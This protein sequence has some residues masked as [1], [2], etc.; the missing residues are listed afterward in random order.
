MECR[1]LKYYMEAMW[2]Q[3]TC[4]TSTSWAHLS[5]SGPG[6]KWNKFVPTLPISALAL[7]RQILIWYDVQNDDFWAGISACA[8]LKGAILVLERMLGR[9]MLCLVWRACSEKER[10][11]GISQQCHNAML[12]LVRMLCKRTPCWNQPKMS[13]NAMLGLARMLSKRMSPWVWRTCSL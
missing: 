7:H 10:H 3:S 5:Q 11:V 6:W 9:I 4:N 8:Q 2:L 1:L 12:N 13:N